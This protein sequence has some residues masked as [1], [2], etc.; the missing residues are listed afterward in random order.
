MTRGGRCRLAAT[1]LQRSLLSELAAVACQ[2]CV[3]EWIERPGVLSLAREGLTV[4]VAA[5]TSAPAHADL[6]SPELAVDMAMA[7]DSVL[8][9]WAPARDVRGRAAWRGAIVAEPVAL[10]RL[11]SASLGSLAQTVTALVA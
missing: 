11:E 9:A 4:F 7:E 1:E 10:L 5:A 2:Q 3:V 6:P 8:L